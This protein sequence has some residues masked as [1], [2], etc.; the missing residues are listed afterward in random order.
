MQ[1]HIDID[2]DDAIEEYI[3]EQEDKSRSMRDK[4][5][6]IC[7]YMGRLIDAAMDYNEAARILIDLLDWFEDEHPGYIKQE[8][9]AIEQREQDEKDMPGGFN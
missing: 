4:P 1:M 6:V 9:D 2:I 3:K 7:N 8:R 5:S